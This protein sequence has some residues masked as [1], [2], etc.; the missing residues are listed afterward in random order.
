MNHSSIAAAAAANCT[1]TTNTTRLAERFKSAASMGG[2]KENRAPSAAPVGIP[3]FTFVEA[4]ERAVDAQMADRRLIEATMDESQMGA[5][6]KGGKSDPTKTT[7][8]E[9]NI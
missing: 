4:M 1:A 9:V 3:L 7:S 2:D 5:R 8:V 6:V